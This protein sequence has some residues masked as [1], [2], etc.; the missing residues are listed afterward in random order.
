MDEAGQAGTRWT[1]RRFAEAV[2]RGAGWLA[3][4]FVLLCV[5][6]GE[7]VI[8]LVMRLVIWLVML[9]SSVFT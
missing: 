6:V 8:R 7:L 9:K 2:N 4:L 1:P 5:I 3:C